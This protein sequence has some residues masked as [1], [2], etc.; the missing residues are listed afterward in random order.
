MLII[1]FL[2]MC[3]ERLPNGRV[4]LMAGEAALEMHGKEEF[5]ENFSYICSL[6]HVQHLTENS[7]S[8][9]RFCPT[10]SSAIFH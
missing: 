10:F 1:L 6:P 2:L 9:L 7:S 3:G 8:T 4:K 5:E